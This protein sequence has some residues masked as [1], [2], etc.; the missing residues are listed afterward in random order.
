MLDSKKAV[1]PKFH[2]KLKDNYTTY[3]Q[4]IKNKREYSILEKR[5][6]TT[7]SK[8]FER[9]QMIGCGVSCTHLKDSYTHI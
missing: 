6:M 5:E 1:K 8:K 4:K 7:A 9:M 2:G 3:E